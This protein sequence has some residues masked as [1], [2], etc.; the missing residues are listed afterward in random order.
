MRPITESGEN[1]DKFFK[2]LLVSWV[3]WR[4]TVPSKWTHTH[5]H[6]H[7]SGVVFDRSANTL[8]AV[9]KTLLEYS[10]GLLFGSFHV[11]KRTK[12][13]LCET[14]LC[15]W[16]HEQRRR[17]YKKYWAYKRARISNWLNFSLAWASMRRWVFLA[18]ELRPDSD[19]LRCILS[20][21]WRKHSHTHT[22]MLFTYGIWCTSKDM[23]MI[24]FHGKSSP[25]VF[26]ISLF[27]MTRYLG[28]Q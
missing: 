13:T 1:V 14:K 24:I 17:I 10:L 27:Q 12:K 18:A 21:R 5:T 26:A 2:C 16:L 7:F 15:S 23:L 8:R 28:I 20:P 19:T 3:S 9:H 11:T 25:T 6:M 22:H 4:H